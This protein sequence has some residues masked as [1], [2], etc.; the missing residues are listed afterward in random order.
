MHSLVSRL[1][2]QLNASGAAHTHMRQL[3][4]TGFLD[5]LVVTCRTP[6]GSKPGSLCAG[7]NVACTCGE[8][9]QDGQQFSP[10]GWEEHAG[11]RSRKPAQCIFH[12]GKTAAR[13]CRS[14]G[15][16]SVAI[17]P[18]LLH[19]CNCSVRLHAENSAGCRQQACRERRG[20]A[21]ACC[22]A[23][24][25]AA[26]A[27]GSNPGAAA[28]A[29][30][31]AVFSSCAAGCA[32]AAAA[33]AGAAAAAAGSGSPT[34]PAGTSCCGEPA[35]RRGRHVCGGGCHAASCRPPRMHGGERR[36]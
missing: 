9:G 16:L 31:E 36:S 33:A 7:G 6:L 10:S 14:Y 25:C 19:P 12:E 18:C 5:G 23:P 28:A 21:R 35:A 15:A 30:E 2:A 20:S 22:A 29:E 26:A 13:L 8:C 34:T 11:S 32:D 17:Q 1:Q 3:L 4:S 24:T 27:R